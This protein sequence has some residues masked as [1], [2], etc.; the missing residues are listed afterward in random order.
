MK[1]WFHLI[2]LFAFL[3]GFRSLATETNVVATPEALARV[4]ADFFQRMAE[5]D[6]AETNAAPKA[7]PY[8]PTGRT[9]DV[10]GYHIEGN[11]GVLPPERFGV[12]SN[13]TGIVDFA[14]VR[15]GLGVLQLIYRELGF[16]TVSVTLPQQKLTNGIVRVKV[17]EGELAQIKVA[18]NRYYSSNNVLRA[19]PS[20]KTNILLNTKWFQPELDRANVNQD[21]QIY[22]VISPGLEPGT[23]DLTL[24]VKDRFPL[25][26][27]VEINDKS[28]PGTPL[29][30]VDSAVQYGNFWQLNHQAGFDYNFSP[31]AF[32]SGDNGDA[33]YEQPMVASFSGYY[34]V[35]LGSGRGLRED[36]E[37]LPVDFGY[38]EVTH[39]FNLP[40]ATGNPEI[41]FYASRSVSDTPVNYG[42]LKII[43]TNTLADISS[44]SAEHDPTFNNN[45]GMKLAIPVQQFWGI[46][47]S[48][49]LGAD[50]KSYEAQGYSTNLTYFDLYALDTFGNRVLVTNQTI[51]LPSNTRKQLYYIPLSLGW[52]AA[53]PDALGS[54]SFSYNESFFFH[55]LASARSDFQGVASSSAAGG[56]YT[57][58]TAGLVRQQ[59]L[60]GNWTAIL[61]ANGQW[62][63]APLISNEQ[64]ALGGT[65]GVRGYQE[66]E[67]YGDTGWRL[68]FDLR[69]PPVNVG[70]FPT[71]TGDVPAN[72]RCSWF[73]DYGEAFRIDRTASYSQ[74]VGGLSRH[75]WGTG[76]GFYLTASEHFTARLTLGWALLG[77]PEN[78]AGSAQA[79]FSVGY[80]F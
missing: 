46:Q 58:V 60:P 78:T 76:V 8:K 80:Q 28:T 57:T 34:R 68:L 2:A 21:R 45:M 47:S 12:L 66:G 18:G 39:R 73:M 49:L 4:R 36:Y 59:N 30:R 11:Y 62:S 9:F 16:V 67:A 48:F 20:L 44:Q 1:F 3:A 38:D 26:G 75:E 64:F 31:Q 69:A 77:N 7:A 42:P 27:H 79:Y 52:V 24:Q 15:D 35:P 14:R 40:P 54:F 13:Y 50:Y 61:N 56:D 55:H 6:A 33:F 41:T 72:L 51:R 63:S 65:S 5:L 19:L 32:K 17:V 37:N 43:F 25:H 70:Y 23:S 22:P 74:Q 53:R 29:L 10:R 71:A